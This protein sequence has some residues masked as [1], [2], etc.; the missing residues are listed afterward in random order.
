[1]VD[2]QWFFW[3]PRVL[4]WLVARVLRLLFWKSHNAYFDI[5]AVQFSPL[6]GRIFFSDFR[7]ISRNQSFRCLRGY[8]IW[9]FWFRHVRDSDGNKNTRLPF[10]WTVTL[11]GAEWFL[12]NRTPSFD[13]ILEQLGVPKDSSSSSSSTSAVHSTDDSHSSKREKLSPKES[14]STKSSNKKPTS[15]SSSSEGTTDWL[16]EFLPIEIKCTTGAILM[17]NQTTPSIIIAGF[18]SCRG[19]YAAVKSRSRFDR[20]KQAYAFTFKKPKIVFRTNP[21]YEGSLFELGEIAVDSLKR[22]KA[23]V[24]EDLRSYPSKHLSFAAFQTLSSRFAHLFRPHSKKKEAEKTDRWAWK[25]LARY[26]VDEKVNLPYHEEYA[27]VTTLLASP[28][29]DLTYYCDVAGPVPPVN[30][31]V[32]NVASS[33]SWDIGNG[34]LSPEWGMDLEIK[35]G[36]ITYGPW[37]DR[38][39]G[40][41]QQA[42]TPATFFDHDATPRLKPGD[43]RVHTAFKMFVEFSSGVTYR[44]PTRES[45]KDWQYRDMDAASGPVARPFGWIDIALGSDSTVTFV[46]PVVATSEGYDMRIEIHLD[47][48]SAASSVN[49]VPFVSAKSCR[50]HC[51]LPSPLRWNVLRTWTFDVN[52]AKPEIYLLRDH[53]FLMTDL[54]KDWTSGPPGEQHHFVQYNYVL[55]VALT[56]Y[57]LKLYLNDHNIINNPTT[58]GDNSPFLTVSPKTKQLTRRGKAL[59]IASGPRLTSSVFIPSHE[60]QMQQSDIKFD[61]SFVNLDLSMSLPDWNTH[62]AFLTERTRSFASAPQLTIDG[63]YRFFA[64]AHPD[65]VEQLA[66]NVKSEHI[67]FKALGWLIRHTFNVRPICLMYFVGQRN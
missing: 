48:F 36:T 6:G 67:I 2:T 47:H 33:E 12:Y 10:R 38:Q 28:E 17:G 29:M 9:H 66:L 37:A 24:D 30:E 63:S 11:E 50:V 44:I 42:F 13:A 21:D 32:R 34:D 8:V 14:A 49:Y 65:H 51:A 52:L 53:I 27:K 43:E 59:L 4:G 23:L 64:D 15:S 55:N 35:G 22:E 62:A 54:A 20:Y 39:R 57:S 46:M 1:M 40:H 56:D 16:R 45:S 7:Y 31:Q 58:D 41:F 19:T 60:Y 5:G 3:A 25:G 26:N 61:V 18:D